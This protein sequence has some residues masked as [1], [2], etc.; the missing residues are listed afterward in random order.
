M[1]IE[2]T[3]TEIMEYLRRHVGREVELS[4]VSEK[5]V[6]VVTEV[7]YRLL[8]K[9]MLDVDVYLSLDEIDGTG[10]FLS[11]VFPSSSMDTIVRGTLP[12]LRSKISEK[13]P[14]I[15]MLNGNNVVVHLNKISQLRDALKNVEIKDI[16]F[17]TN[18]ILLTLKL[19]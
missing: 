8:R 4:Y 3:Y 18:N 2:L 14:M 17:K 13:L 16:Y 12:L 9:H 11:Y 5:T 7:E 6:R 15:D 1:K 10:L 19:K